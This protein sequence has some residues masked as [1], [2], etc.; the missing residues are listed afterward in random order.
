[1]FKPGDIITSRKK[2]Q[3]FYKVL[4]VLEDGLLV[5]IVQAIKLPKTIGR[6]D[7]IKRPEFFQKVSDDSNRHNS[8]KF[9]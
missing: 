4:S 5:R 9:K 8:I 3:T 2:Y 7:M 1:M 6:V